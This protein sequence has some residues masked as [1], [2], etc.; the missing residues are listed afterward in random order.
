MLWEYVE[1]IELLNQEAMIS[2]NEYGEFGSVKDVDTNQAL[3]YDLEKFKKALKESLVNPAPFMHMLADREDLNSI[4]IQIISANKASMDSMI[5]EYFLSD[6]TPSNSPESLTFSQPMAEMNTDRLAVEY[7]HLLADKSKEKLR[8]FVGHLLLSTIDKQ[9]PAYLPTERYLLVGDGSDWEDIWGL[10]TPGKDILDPP[11]SDY[12]YASLATQVYDLETGVPISPIGPT[13]LA[14]VKVKIPLHHPVPSNATVGLGVTV[15]EKDYPVDNYTIIDTILAIESIKNRNKLR[16]AGMPAEK[17]MR[18][19]LSNL[20][21]WIQQSAS[22]EYEYERMFRFVRWYAEATVTKLSTHILQRT[23]DSWMSAIHRNGDLGIPYEQTGWRYLSNASVIQTMSTSAILSFWKDNHIDGQ[24][25]IRGYFDNPRQEGTMEIKVDGEPIG[26][27][28]A[29]DNGAFTIT[30]ELPAGH[31]N[32]EI[33]FN[34]ESGR[35]SLSSLEISGSVFVSAVTIADDSDTNGF[36]ACTTLMDML[37]YYYDI[38]HGR[39][40]VKG[41]MAVRQRKVWNQT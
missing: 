7:G 29:A 24:I 17:T 12:D 35:I 26:S 31:H 41:A 3:I 8:G 37:L 14:E 38:H 21:A 1:R 30:T 11:D 16:F 18:E 23:Y 9:R 13:N 5:Q 39:H 6:R 33:V 22:G 2:G 19:L 40:K 25:T 32:Y 15:G 27:L 20:Y 4:I 28:G 34:G 36:K 10:Y